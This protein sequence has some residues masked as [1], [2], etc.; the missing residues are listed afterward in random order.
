MCACI[1]KYII[2]RGNMETKTQN[3]EK[4][5]EKNHA[6]V[7]IIMP[8]YNASK[9]LNETIE[10]VIA[11]TYT[12]WELILVD[13]CSTDNSIELIKRFADDRIKLME[14]QTNSGAAVSR[15]RAIEKANGKYI[16]FLDSDDLW[17]KDK[18]SKHLDFMNEQNSAFSCTNYSVVDCQNEKETVFSPKKDTY[19]YKD[20]LKHCYIGCS[21]VIYD[22]EKLGKVYMPT[23]AEK[24]EDFACWLQ[25]LKTGIDVSCLH[26]NLTTYKIHQNSVSTNKTKMIK[27]QW[28][29]YRKIEKI[30]I[31]K[32]LYYMM[33]WAIKGFFKYR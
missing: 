32:S 6:L 5:V 1:I 10:S 2:N 29:V 17:S 11:Q 15:N 4:Q 19:S 8:I 33:H 22:S 26:E 18:L 14:N 30:C 24:R 16:A 7:S 20:I 25:I 3:I 9:Y 21:T 23:Q 31:V 27:Y 28:R 12:N 13:D